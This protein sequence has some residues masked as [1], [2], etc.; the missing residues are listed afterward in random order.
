VS[1]ETTT[2][3]D[4]GVADVSSSTGASSTSSMV[5]SDSTFESSVGASTDEHTTGVPVDPGLVAWYRFED[6]LDDGAE[7]S[8]RNG[9][10]A[11]CTACPTQTPGVDGNAAQFDG[12]TQFLTLPASS[13]LQSS[14]ALSVSAWVRVDVGSSEFRTIAGHPFGDETWNTWELAV[15]TSGQAVVQVFAYFVVSADATAGGVVPVQIDTGEWFHVAFSWDGSEAILYLHGE[16]E[17]QWEVS[18]LLYDDQHSVRIG[19][20]FDYHADES[21]FPGAIDE[22]RIYDRALDP[23]E[24]A[25]LAAL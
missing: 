5:S 21:F 19:A 15:H 13:L 22:I 11:T 14:G 4:T 6:P 12:S 7:D 1:A 17:E 8:S 18:S 9:L 25:E 20:D 3:L 24:I 16:L 10:H 23:D 2:G